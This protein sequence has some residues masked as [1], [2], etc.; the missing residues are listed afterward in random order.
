MRDV[1][2]GGERNWELEETP[3]LGRRYSSLEHKM[4][5][6][7]FQSETM[8]KYQL[9]LQSESAYRCISELGE[10]GLVEF[11][12]HNPDL[13]SFQR[14]FVSEIKRC[15][16]MERICRFLEK[17][18]MMDDIPL[19]ELRQE[20]TTPPMREMLE[21]ETHL[22]KSEEDLIQVNN[23]YIVLK[24][25]LLELMEM[26]VL[27]RKANNLFTD[28]NMHFSEEGDLFQEQGISYS[29]IGVGEMGFHIIAGVI[30]R[31][32]LP[33]FER[34]IWRISKGN[35][36]LKASEI[37]E[38]L[39]NPTTNESL[40]KSAFMVFFQGEQLRVRIK[41][42]C[43][44]FHATVYPC[45]TS[46]SERI[47]NNKNVNTELEDLSKV[48][49]KTED[50]LH[51]LL[52]SEAENLRSWYIKIRKIKG[53]H[54]CLNMFNLDVTNNAMI[55]D[56]WLPIANVEEIY[57][58]LKKGAE[59]SGSN[60]SPILKPVSSP[61]DP[62]TFNQ[63]NKFTGGF[64]ALIDSYG[65]NSYREINP[66]PFAVITFPF[67]FGVMFGDIGHGL[68]M[69]LTA[70]YLVLNE[71]KLKDI[72]NELFVML[73]GGRYIVLLM[74]IFSIYVGL[75]YNDC[76]SRSFN[77]FG[78]AWSFHGSFNDI[79]ESVMLDPANITQNSGYTYVLGIDP[80]WQLSS[81]KI[82]FLNTYKM[83]I[84]LIFGLTHMVFG[85]FVSLWNKINFKKTFDIAFEFIPQIL[86][87]L[88]T[89]CYLIFLIFFKWIMYS[90]GNG[91]W[92][93]HCAPSLLITFINMM[94]MKQDKPD[95]K[96]EALCQ[97]KETYMFDGQRELQQVLL[98]FGLLMIPV[99]FFG[100][101]IKILVSSFLRRSNYSSIG[102]ET[103][104]QVEQEN[105]GDILIFQ[106][107][108]TIEYVLGSVSHTASYLRLWALSLAHSQLS[109]V[110]W[111]MVMKSGFGREM[112]HSVMLF[113]VF[114]FWAMATVIILVLMEGLSAFLHTL[115]LHWV[116]FM[117][118]FYGG[119]GTAFVP[120]SFQ[121]YL[122]ESYLADKEFLKS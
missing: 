40:V 82:T 8:S 7:L 1:V 78:S 57:D 68:I 38:D 39:K 3:L 74:G 47:E 27:F 122:R 50:H 58:A 53:V 9:F 109:E 10:I 13:S 30:D 67:I 23:S 60:M 99:M 55:A 117:S 28:Q 103:E 12:D 63:T 90:A 76:F 81:N 61:L 4:A 15:E 46:E 42:V 121:T 118:K 80:V 73:F 91:I 101:P 105:F 107:I 37:S 18:C 85:V 56:C 33:S 71:K 106:A 36:L 45:P 17:E 102:D 94:L 64:Q 87:L 98:I 52:G 54:H 113:F 112:K 2:V 75:I 51:N 114:N 104:T 72:E 16:N 34:M 5:S 93:E 84:S 6:S 120:F 66:A 111:N 29:S 26:K 110:L 62:P 115:R 20:P 65:I 100:K 14:K 11:L 35:V 59:A 96:L 24:K 44:G 79:G 83:K 70:L 108:H 119:Q 88:C 89:F 48:I 32:R 116:E 22:I 97:G 95:P 69:L 19:A 43:D 49:K 31:N 86:F 92:S 21:L 25:K 41:K 77:I